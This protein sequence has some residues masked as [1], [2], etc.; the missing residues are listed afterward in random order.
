MGFIINVP[1][2]KVK[3]Q[4]FFR[5]GDGRVAEQLLKA[6][7]IHSSPE[8]VGGEAVAQYV[9]VKAGSRDTGCRAPFL[10][11]SPDILSHHGIAASR[12]EQN[13]RGALQKK[14]PPFFQVKSHPF[15]HFSKKGNCPLLFSLSEGTEH[16]CRKI[17]I[18]ESQGAQLA[19]PEAAAV[20]RLE[21]SPVPQ[22]EGTVAVTGMKQTIHFSFAQNPGKRLPPSWKGGKPHLLSRTALLL[23]VAYPGPQCGDDPLPCGRT[24]FSLGEMPLEQREG[25]LIRRHGR[26]ITEGAEISPFPE[27][28]AIGNDGVGAQSPFKE[29]MGEKIFH[30]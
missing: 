13:I 17:N 26:N 7:L 16:P 29:K 15:T 21:K 28:P 22:V 1:Q 24:L 9:G 10:K 4:V 23:E 30:R 27:I 2:L 14:V 5:G 25:P 11:S 3:V 8:K 18:A 12:E 20:R 6:S 19:C